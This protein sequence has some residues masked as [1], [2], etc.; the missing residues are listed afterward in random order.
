MS[1]PNLSAFAVQ[2][3]AVTLFALLLAVAGGVYAFLAMGRAEDPSFT[4]RVLVVSAIWPGATTD[5]MQA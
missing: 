5:Q 3:R 2:E 4:V 1:F